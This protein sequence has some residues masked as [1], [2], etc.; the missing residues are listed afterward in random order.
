MKELLTNQLTTVLEEL[1]A[2]GVVHL[3]S[4]AWPWF[5]SAAFRHLNKDILVLVADDEEAG[6]L[7]RKLKAFSIPALHFPAFPVLPWEELFSP[8]QIKA[9][10][11]LVIEELS[12]PQAHIVVASVSAVLNCF[13]R[14]FR[15]PLGLK[16]HQEI[17]LYSFLEELEVRGYERNYLVEREGEY[18]HRGSLVDLFPPTLE[19]PLRVD[20]S[21]NQVQS[22]RSFDLSTQRSVGSLSHILV[23]DLK[24]AQ[25]SKSE[26]KKAQNLLNRGKLPDEVGALID[27]KTFPGWGVYWTY[28]YSS[29]VT[30]DELLSSSNWLFLLEPARLKE[31]ARRK[32]AFWEETFLEAVEKRGLTR[33]SKFPWKTLSEIV[34]ASRVEL[35]PQGGSLTSPLPTLKNLE[36][37]GNLVNRWLREG[38]KVVLIGEADSLKKFQGELSNYLKEGFEKVDTMEGEVVRGFIFRPLKIVFLSLAELFPRY[39]VVKREPSI[40]PHLPPL[41]LKVGDFVV[42]V[43]HGIGKYQGSE[44]LQ[45]ANSTRDY[46][47]IEYADGLLKVPADQVGRLT[48]YYSSSKTVP[49]IARLN[50]VEWNRQRERAKKSAQKLAIDLLKLYARREAVQGHAFSPDTPWQ[51]ELEESF[52]YVETP[53]QLRALKEVKQDMELAKPM[54]R[55]VFGDVGYGKTE[56]ALRA[57]FKAVMDGKQVMVLVPTTILAEQHFQTFAE[58]LESF[59]IKVELLSR[60]ISLRR[61]REISLKFRQGSVDIL[62][63][64]H[65]LLSSD[66]RPKDLGLLI[67]DEEHRFGVAQKEKI[68]AL[69]EGIDVLT[70]SATPIPRTLQMALSGIREVSVIETPP[71]ARLPIA[72]YVG[73]YDEEKVKLAIRRELARGGQV[74]YVYNSIEQLPRAVSKVRQ[75]FPEAKV[76]MAHGQMNA[77]ELELV[78]WEFVQAEYDILVSTTIVESGIDLPNVNT[79]IVEGA[80]R[81]GLAQAYQLRG[82]V[83]RSSRQAYAYFFFHSH[84]MTSAGWERLKSLAELA[85]LGSGLKLALKD[86]EIRGSGSLFGPQQHG[87]ISAV[88]FDLY[89]QLV[90]E[91]VEDLKGIKPSK[92]KDVEISLPL[93]AYIPKKWMDE[94]RLRLEFYHRLYLARSFEELEDLRIEMIDRF[95]N[96]PLQVA[97][98][99]WIA[100][101]RLKASE[102]KVDAL[103][104]R[105]GQLVVRAAE[106]SQLFKQLRGFYPQAQRGFGEVKLP[107]KASEIKT[108]LD[109][110]FDVIMQKV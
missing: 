19:K 62:I 99:I 108:F 25:L 3:D 47:I 93:A 59:P 29:L 28:L 27:G 14:E 53:D 18:S 23:P 51:Q 21:F 46:L 76:A 107:V 102:A 56:I 83:G 32:I 17:D 78:M 37:V 35:I 2:G 24:E 82:R 33:P 40:A 66:V 106:I 15:F 64:T 96:L 95:G 71:E 10:R 86:L 34:C 7:S 104:W 67:I 85:D 88:G 31:E 52:A 58:R 79:L 50:S 49:Q 73:P 110:L 55:L 109:S 4:A 91:A 68:K 60:F 89:T 75:L 69:E 57:S 77:D 70:L 38:L 105:N 12:K 54:D 74:F 92:V 9:Q 36:Q 1:L 44:R 13:P 84:Q 97:N 26:I 48:R 61:Q 20:F 22:I 98:L 80:E 16:L 41:D 5:L 43:N 63:G 42:H 101:I 87:H 39:R 45:V 72:T 65:R 8:P 6:E 100:S 81:L 103:R 30:L 94:E 11:N 90:K